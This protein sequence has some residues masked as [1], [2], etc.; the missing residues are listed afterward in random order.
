MD[1]FKYYNTKRKQDF[2]EL[3]IRTITIDEHLIR[4]VLSKVSVIEKEKKKDVCDFTEKEAMEYLTSLNKRTYDSVNEIYYILSQYVDW[5]LTQGFVKDGQNHFKTLTVEMVRSCIN[6]MAAD[7][8]II[9]RKELLEGI[10]YLENPRDQFIMLM[11]FEVGIKNKFQDIQLA[12]A[13]NIKGNKL[14]LPDRTVH[15]SNALKKLAYEANEETRYFKNE[16]VFSYFN[17]S[18]YIVKYA[19]QSKKDG[20]IRRPTIYRVINNGLADLGYE[21]LRPKDLERSGIICMIWQL[22]KANKTIPKKIVENKKMYDYIKNQYSFNTYW[23][24]FWSKNER[25]L[26]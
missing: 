12:K 26:V 6:L 4:T 2:I 11:A 18:D 14:Y 13:E 21:G 25:W 23:S 16:K 9:P 15:I 20:E 1:G 24:T 17:P 19:R 8:A 7:S 3:K 10:Q 22:A 5:C